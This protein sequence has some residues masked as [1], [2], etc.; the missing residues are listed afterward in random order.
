MM[1][2]LKSSKSREFLL[3]ENSGD[4]VT[5][6]TR[7]D[8]PLTGREGDHVHGIKDIHGQGNGREWN[9][10]VQIGFVNPNC[11][12]SPSETEPGQKARDS[13][14][15]SKVASGKKI[16]KRDSV[17]LSVDSSG[18]PE[19]SES[20]PEL[21]PKSE[22]EKSVVEKS[23][24]SPTLNP[25]AHLLSNI[26]LLDFATKIVPKH[27]S[28]Q[29]TIIRDKRGLDRTLY[30]TYFMYLQGSTFPPIFESFPRFLR[31]FPDF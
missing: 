4:E 6:P 18:E 30:P 9:S 3:L 14:Q 5:S 10:S 8:H 26:E 17:L 12:L 11:D 20:S 19:E 25:L 7:S 23:E 21:S 22:E 28:Y 2:H 24:A 31:I 13:G 16:P 27:Q 15:K 29:C 1:P